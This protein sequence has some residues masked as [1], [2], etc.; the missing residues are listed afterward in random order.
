MTKPKI[1]VIRGGAIGDF[2]LTLPAIRAIRCAFPNAIVEIL[3]Y[4]KIVSL[5]RDVGLADCI[6][7]IEAR[8]LANFFARDGSLPEDWRDY[9]SEFDI[10]LSYL[11]DP[12]EI[13]RQNIQRCSAAQ[14]IQGPHRPD[15]NSNAHA[16]EVF[17][18]PL[19]RLAIFDSNPTPEIILPPATPTPLRTIL[20]IH[21]GSGSETKNWSEPS[22][23]KLLS[24]LTAAEMDF[25]LI[26]GEAEG[27]RLEKLSTIL[28]QDRFDLAKNLPLGELA[29]RLQQCSAFVGHDSGIT[30]LAAAVGVPCLALWAHTNPEIWRPLGKHVVLL[31]EP[32]GLSRLSVECVADEIMRL[33]ER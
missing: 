1:L 18:K 25:L 26:G 11:Y 22:W 5:A 28:P 6:R 8:P 24:K 3:G 10:I 14:F 33:L 19:V 21:P 4:P 16:T 32:A 13:F 7:H 15:E 17:L 31:R 30:H 27:D 2:I 29:L 20:A 9:F 23:A 12:D